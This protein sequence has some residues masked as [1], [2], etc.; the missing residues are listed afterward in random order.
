MKQNTKYERD[1]NISA[2]LVVFHRYGGVEVCDNS[3]VIGFKRFS[4]FRTT[5]LF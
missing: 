1:K 4:T 5:A 2:S 3:V